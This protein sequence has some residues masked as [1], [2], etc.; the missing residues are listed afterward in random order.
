VN[1]SIVLQNLH[2]FLVGTRLYRL[3]WYLWPLAF[4]SAFAFANL[5]FGILGLS[6]VIPLVLL[7]YYRLALR[8][9]WRRFPPLKVVAALAGWSAVVTF[10]TWLRPYVSDCVIKTSKAYQ[11][12]L[13]LMVLALIH[14]SVHCHRATRIVL[15]TLI[16]GVVL[17]LL[18]L[19][20][21]TGLFSWLDTIG[22]QVSLGRGSSWGRTSWLRG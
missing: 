5:L 15:F 12:P 3:F 16:G 20:K 7:P 1:E 21:C 13:L 8:N 4:V 9:L 6:V 18:S 14:L 2:E 17:V 11:K 22:P 10:V 19:P